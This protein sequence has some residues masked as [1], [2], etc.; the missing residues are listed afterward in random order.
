MLK[1]ILVLAAL[2]LGQTPSVV[3]GDTVKLAGV[4]IQDWCRAPR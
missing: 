3:D 4:S 1:E 2:S